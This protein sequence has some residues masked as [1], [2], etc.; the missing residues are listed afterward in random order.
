M[1]KKPVLAKKY[2]PIILAYIKA[3]INI[4]RMAKAIRSLDKVV[5]NTKSTIITAMENNS[6]VTC[7][8]YIITKEPGTIIDPSITL[9]NGRIVPLSEIKL[10]TLNDGTLVATSDIAKIYSGRKEQEKLAI[11]E[12][13][14]N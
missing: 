3:K 1:D 5:D 6:F 2:M 9:M 12:N 13:I 14:F 11:T 8:K 10:F 4:A 7:G